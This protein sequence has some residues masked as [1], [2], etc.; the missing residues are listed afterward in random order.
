MQI[1]NSQKPIIMNFKICSIPI[2]NSH[3]YKKEILFHKQGK[4]MYFSKSELTQRIKHEVKGRKENDQ[5]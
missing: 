3:S 4:R 1:Q 5:Y 2:T